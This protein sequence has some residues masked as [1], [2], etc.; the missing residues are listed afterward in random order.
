MITQA[1]LQIYTS[2]LI[3]A[4][5]ASLVKKRFVGCVPRWIKGLP[6]VE[7]NWSTLVQTLEGHSLS[8]L[9]MA[10]APCGKLLASSSYDHTIKLWDPRSGALQQ[11]FEGL[12]SQVV[13]LAFSCDSKYLASVTY[14]SC[15]EL[16]DL[17]SGK[18]QQTLDIFPVSEITAFSPNITMVASV[19][20]D[21]RILLWNIKSK[22]VVQEIKSPSCDM[23]VESCGLA[24]SP[25]SKLLASISTE[26]SAQ[27]WDVNSGTLLHTLTGHAYGIEAVAFSP[28]STQL[29]SSSSDGTVKLWN[30]RSG[31]LRMSL[32]CS[33]T[34]AVNNV[35]F[36]PDGARLASVLSNNSTQL[37]DVETGVLQ[38]TIDSSSTRHCIVVFS[39]DSRHLALTSYKTI[40]LRDTRS[41][42]P[43]RTKHR[44]G[45][46][47]SIYL[48]GTTTS[49]F[50]P[51][52]KLRTVVSDNRVEL[53]DTSSVAMQTEFDHVDINGVVF[54][55]PGTQ[56]ATISTTAIKLWDMKTKTL[57][58]TF[59][60]LPGSSFK[61]LVFSPDSK[62]LSSKSSEG[63]IILWSTMS[64]EV[65]QRFKRPSDR[66]ETVGFSPS[67]K[68]LIVASA[69]SIEIWNVE[70]GALQVIV[71]G[72]S[73]DVNH[74][75]FSPDERQL[76]LTLGNTVVILNAVSGEVQQMLRDYS[77]VEERV[78]A[79]SP[80]SKQLAIASKETIQV[81]DNEGKELRQTFKN[82]AL[83][84]YMA[85]S[86]DGALL[87]TSTGCHQIGHVSDSMSLPRRGPQSLHVTDQWIYYGA[88]RILR[89]PPEYRTRRYNISTGVVGLFHSQLMLSVEFDLDL[90][91]NLLK[92]EG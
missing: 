60:A 48:T 82:D 58:Q 69:A 45:N 34:A 68:Q 49:L 52:G 2:G 66:R 61:G 57:Q 31:E 72:F 33:L 81:W 87:K 7:E 51:D 22:A 88:E 47:L 17:S 67:F 15:F 85:F 20:R 76:V 19:L 10:Y 75:N 80:D 30:C 89:L 16:R 83:P 74:L 40:E 73:I 53:W 77:G 55:P 29:A 63:T 92:Y 32:T 91:F 71:K 38:Q 11:T 4:P 46:S 86:H 90:L 8:V 26:R 18:S 5:T 28:D 62:L 84:V 9:A 70:S 65:Q 64:G 25:D 59:E 1:P 13:A 36:S 56:L 37:W 50:S 41:T 14:N 79:F 39:P 6:R 42:A 24:F 44:F 3:F 54:S 78:V 21:D 27:I 35:A 43:R 12:S 23:S